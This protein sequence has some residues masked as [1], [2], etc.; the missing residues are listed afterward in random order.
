MTSFDVAIPNYNYG[1]YLRECV[2]SVA[3]QDVDALRI[4]IIDNAS[5]DDSV[6]I[7]QEIADKDPRV[8]LRLRPRNLGPHASFNEAVDWAA[9]DCFLILCADDLLAPGALRRAGEV[10]AADKSLAFCYGRCVRFW[11]DLSPP[12]IDSDSEQVRY[13]RMSGHKFIEQFCRLGVFQIPGAT[14]VTRTT[15]QKVA[16]HYREELPHTDDYEIWLRLALA[17]N[18]AILDN[19]QGM[20]GAHDNNRSKQLKMSQISHIQETE[21]AAVSFFSRKDLAPDGARRLQRIAR[22]GFAARA[23]WAAFGALSR[24]DPDAGGL[25]RYALVK[26]PE[27]ALAPPLDY[28]FHRPDARARLTQGFSAVTKRIHPKRG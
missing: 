19:V 23:Y 11:R 25:M 26:A 4:L 28:L 1:R 15:A 12:Q 7:A 6:R 16:G 20:L 10:L 8:E 9:S 24:G 22:R 21:A 3:S 27:M 17:G 2:A 5:T 13:H 14:L 18:V